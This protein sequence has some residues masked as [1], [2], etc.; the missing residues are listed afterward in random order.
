MSS[1]GSTHSVHMLAGCD[2]GRNPGY[3]VNTVVQEHDRCVCR[4]TSNV[5]RQW[6]CVATL[7]L[8]PMD[9]GRVSVSVGR[10]VDE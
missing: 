7:G 5:S 1:H 10:I 6:H 9:A 3:R 4:E 2:M 8:L